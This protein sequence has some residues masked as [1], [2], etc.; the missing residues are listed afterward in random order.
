M[1]SDKD[2]HKAY[3]E[4]CKLTYPVTGKTIIDSKNYPNFSVLILL[5][6]F[7]TF[8]VI[9]SE[10]IRLVLLDTGSSQEVYPTLFWANS[11]LVTPV[12]PFLWA[13]LG[14]CVFLIKKHSDLAAALEFHEHRSTNGWGPR[15]I[16]GTVL[17]G[18]APLL[19]DTNFIKESGIDDNVVA[20]L[21]GLSV[22]VFYGVLE[23][24]IHEL[25]ERFN[26]T[27]MKSKQA[28]THQQSI[29]ADIAKGLSSGKLSAQ[30][31]KTMLELLTRLK[32]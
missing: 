30:E 28:G 17:G 15:I 20:F 16:L 26:L 4:L 6:I 11:F 2:I 31:A 5:T 18:M 22:K 25:A 12:S 13:L 19:F 32:S 14:S 7:L 29:E 8:F 24:S 9:G 3:L 27:N 1:S 23:K 10:M 21:I